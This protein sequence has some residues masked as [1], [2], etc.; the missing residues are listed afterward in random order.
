MG[1]QEKRWQLQIV[2]NHHSQQKKELKQKAAQTH[3]RDRSG[4]E[5]TRADAR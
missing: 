1:A 4:A 3:Q 2:E 5:Q